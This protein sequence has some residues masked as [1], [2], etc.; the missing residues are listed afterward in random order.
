MPAAH[1]IFP[2]VF[3]SSV[4]GIVIFDARGTIRNFSP[5]A[6]RLLGYAAS[7]VI[8]SNALDLL[9]P[10]D[11]EKFASYVE[12]YQ[13]TGISRLVL[14][15]A[16][17][18]GFR[19]DGSIQPMNISVGQ[20]EFEGESLF[21]G[22]MYD[23]SLELENRQE[24]ARS[25][26][27]FRQ[28]AES[29]GE[30]FALR[31]IAPV[32]YVYINPAVTKIYGL[33]V[34]AV[35]A[36]A[37]VFFD[38]VHPDD[39]EAVREAMKIA[40]SGETIA[41]EFRIIVNEEIRWI[42]A[43][44]SPVE[45]LHEGSPLVAIHV[46]NITQQKQFQMA[47][48]LSRE[49]AERANN[50]KS[51]FLSRMSHELRTPLNAILGFAQLLAMDELNPEQ[52]ESVEQITQGGQHL[53]NLINDVLDISRVET[54]QM[55]FS[56]ERVVIADVLRDVNGLV[57]PLTSSRNIRINLPTGD[58]DACVVADRQ[59]LRQVLL[60]LMSNAIKYNRDNGEVSI[61]CATNEEK[62]RIT[63]SDTGIGIPASE[64]ERLFT[65]FDRL[66]AEATGIEGTGV[67]LALSKSLMDMM[68]GTIEVTSTHGAG[69][70]FSLILPLDSSAT[71]QSTDRLDLLDTHHHTLER[72]GNILDVVYIED[73]IA[74]VTLVEQ[75]A[76]HFGNV[77]I[78][79]S[80]QGRV[81]LDLIASIS[82]GLV[83]LDLHLPDIPGEEVLRRLRAD[84]VTADT[85][86][87]I[88]SADATPGR[89]E[90]LLELG[91]N[92]YVAK[93]FDVEVLTEWFDWA[94]SLKRES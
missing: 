24:L 82:P 73:N 62:L 3:E 74:N 4:P 41:I 45:S 10:E 77:N 35:L 8:G 46:T 38:V 84:A 42:I 26:A 87:L 94:A 43:R 85:P 20:F 70:Q 89:I 63:V 50:A 31:T 9:I 7:E 79:H 11:R 5:S 60:N 15:T 59:R 33:S 90:R 14:D 93:P 56:E 78:F 51:E 49:E 47:L 28:L 1:D 16:E 22:T 53:L 75:V 69:S 32:R 71:T 34:E 67:G 6:E 66:G 80:L 25:E 48:E 92:G 23:I 64:L 37:A 36:D 40:D 61:S 39:A 17:V 18:S 68:N 55:E 12:E 54:G 83:L 76:R 58:L 21:T 29:I 27:R 44:Y 2:S 30:M 88:I 65:P 91:A 72:S 13:R 52:T 57:S 19:K 86:I 81:G